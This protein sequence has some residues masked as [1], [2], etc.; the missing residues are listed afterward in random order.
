MSN[1]TYLFPG[2]PE[3]HLRAEADSLYND[4]LLALEFTFHQ[5]YDLMYE[6]TDK[7]ILYDFYGSVEIS[8]ELNPDDL[9]PDWVDDILDAED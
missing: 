8:E 6:F 4:L 2:H 5:V 9:N 1:V 3:Y 7:D